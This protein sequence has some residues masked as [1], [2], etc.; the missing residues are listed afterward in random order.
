[1]VIIIEG[2]IGVGK[3]TLGHVLSLELG[4]P[5]YTELNNKFTLSML[6]EFYKDKARWAFPVQ[7]NFLNERFKLIKNIF[8]AKGE[9]ILDRSIYGDCVFASFLNDGGYMSDNEYKIYLNLL[10]NMLEYSQKPALMIYLDCS[11]AEAENRIKRRNRSCEACIS[12]DYLE[13]LN[14]RYLDWYDSY[15]LSPKLMFNYDRIN[16][17]DDK[18]KNNLMTFIKEKLVI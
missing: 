5:F 3:T 2:L 12:K 18:H 4:I 11:V 16:I 7:I 6:N 9:G 13:K 1:M 15:D 8:K 17:F 14:N 10:D